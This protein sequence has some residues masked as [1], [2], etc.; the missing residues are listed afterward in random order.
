MTTGKQ[1]RAPGA[2]AAE[3]LQDAPSPGVRALLAAALAAAVAWVLLP[4]LGGDF[5]YDDLTLVQRNPWITSL[6]QALSA[7]DEP[8]WG[9]ES[10]RYADQVGFWRPLTVLALAAGRALG[11]GEPWGHH[12]VSAA[13]LVLACLAAWRLV[14]RV[15]GCAWTGWAAALLFACHPMTTQAGAWIAAVNDPLAA[16][17]V[18]AA[19][20]SRRRWQEADGESGVPL[21]SGLLFLL[22]LL[23][24]EQALVLLPGA[25]LLDLLWRRGLGP[26][27]TGLRSW[28][29]LAGALVLWWLLRW[30]AVFGEPSGGLGGAL[31]DLGLSAGRTWELRA[32]ALGAWI[33]GAALPFEGQPF[34]RAVRPVADWSDPAARLALLALVGWLVS[35]AAALGLGRR[36]A[37]L[38]L[39]AMPVAV[40]PVLLDPQRA[41]AF[42]I[43]DRYALLLVLAACALAAAGLVRSLPR[44]AALAVTAAAAAGMS[45]AARDRAALYADNLTFHRAATLESP[46]V[47]P[48]WWGLGREL[49]MR[50]Q[51]SAE[52]GLVDEAMAA[53][54]KTLALGH[55]YGDR[56]PRLTADA[57]VPDRLAELLPLINDTSARPR[58]DPR[59]MVSGFDRL[60][61]NLGQAWC[62]LLNAT[63]SPDP[64]FETPAAVFEAVAQ[65]MP[66]ESEP[67]VGLGATLLAQGD[68]A[69]SEREL[70]EATRLDARNAEAWF[71]LGST[72]SR[73]GKHD[74]A[75]QAYREAVALR[76]DRRSQVRLVS[77][78]ID[79]GRLEE[80]ARLLGELREAA[81]RDPELA[82]LE[83]VRA[84]SARDLTRA[85]EWFDRAIAVEPDMG[86]AHRYRGTV[87]A[88][89]GQRS[90]AIDALGRACEL[91]PE[92]FDAHYRTAQLLLAEP[93][94]AAS[95]RPYLEVAYQRSPPGELRAA[96]AEFMAQFAGGDPDALMSLAALEQARGD[97]PAALRWTERVLGN[98]A[99]WQG[100]PGR[101]GS[102]A[103][104]HELRGILFE[105]LERAAE[106]QVEYEAALALDP[107]A[108]WPQHNLGILLV[109]L[110]RPDLARPLVAGALENLDALGRADDPESLRSAAESTL[111]GVLAA[112]DRGEAE[113]VG[114]RPDLPAAPRDR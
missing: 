62:Y 81:P 42:P 28:L 83:G 103:K 50:Y 77:T 40:L 7:W 10:E 56:Q 67:R 107:R 93:A 34:F 11:G 60:Q 38:A 26:A 113:F 71:N 66:S 82:Y 75:I 5:V 88:Q 100:R 44:G 114:P 102:L 73:A 12:L 8:L 27:A 69:G 86:E 63:V 45:I 6:G 68:L 76:P 2:A 89:Q 112:I 47:A 108:F 39:A 74:E 51:V 92:S 65:A 98:P 87:L 41:G 49:L 55:D 35:L 21:G 46:D 95:A 58:P 72:L 91:L 16:A 1:E 52:T 106:A 64:D 23:T 84:L 110:G 61:G 109:K 53:F 54:L 78:A 36:G 15:T 9:F 13:A 20:A 48:A 43:A 25:L 70:R 30:V 97:W 14:S 24:K 4:A 85:L 94:T 104:V 80:A 18:L 29:P 101:E 3:P 90:A 22:A 96:L 37:A 79:A 105:R 32:E 33:A 19:L 17:L 57:P 111:Q 59:V 31:V 99:A